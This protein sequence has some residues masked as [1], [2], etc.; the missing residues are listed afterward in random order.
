MQLLPSP[1]YPGLQVQLWDPLVLLQTA[2]MSQLWRL[3]VH[4]SISMKENSQH[5]KCQ[6]SL[7]NTI[8]REVHW[9]P[10]TT[11]TYDIQNNLIWH[12]RHENE[13]SSSLGGLQ[14]VGQN[15]EIYNEG[16]KCW[17]TFVKW[18]LFEYWTYLSPSPVYLHPSP[19]KSMLYFGPSTLSF[20]SDN[21]D[22][23]GEGIYGV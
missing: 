4:S 10:H 14:Q 18:P 16:Q 17:D 19:P 21:I 12:G 9:G 3:I 6:Y 8:F 11:E 7:I 5:E 1:E 22:S 13:K 2:L 20:T 23:G 15:L